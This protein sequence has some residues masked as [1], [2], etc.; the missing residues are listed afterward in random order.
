MFEI[1]RTER[2]L[3]DIDHNH[4][5]ECIAKDSVYSTTTY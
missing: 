4:I 1:S 5:A 3:D 2:A